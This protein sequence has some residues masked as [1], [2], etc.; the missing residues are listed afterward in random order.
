MTLVKYGGQLLIIVL[1]SEKKTPK[2]N[3]IVCLYELR[4]KNWHTQMD[5][6]SK[7]KDKN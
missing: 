6:F 2:D 4:G 7:S 1:T 3:N 5:H